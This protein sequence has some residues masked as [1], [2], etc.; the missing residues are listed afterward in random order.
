M[1][2]ETRTSSN[3]D[4]IRDQQRETWD[5]FSAG[6]KKWDAMVLGWLAPYGEAMIRRANLREDSNVLDIAAGTGEPGLTAAARVP[7]GRVTVTDLAE[8]M[9]AVTAENAARRGLRNVETRVCD[10][11]ALPFADASVD[12][13]LCRFGFMFFPDVGAAAREFARVAKPGAMVCAAVWSEPAK[14]PW[15]TT[16]MGTIARHVAMPAPPPDSPGLFRCASAGYM[17]KAFAEAGLRNISEEEVS[18]DMVHDTPQ[19]YWEFMNDV[20]APVVAGLAKADEG[21]R[22][23]I[24][25]EVLD[26]A[27]QSMRNDAVQLRS[28]ATV[29]VGTR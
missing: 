7:R 3:L 26:L 16:I 11:G 2:T 24:K 4:Q 10:A 5:R 20:A 13:V 1:N 19:R 14:N 12:A 17:R 29:I 27:R 15:A 25:A 6:W 22:E 18:S 21:A 28:T 23:K 8:G 9:L